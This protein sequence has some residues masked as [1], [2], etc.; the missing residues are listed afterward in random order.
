MT[1]G[2]PAVATCI[3][4]SQT[5]YVGQVL[6]VRYAGRHDAIIDEDTLSSAPT[7]GQRPRPLLCDQW[8]STEHLDR[9]RL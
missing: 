8:Q 9:P 4:S 7:K 5:I 3:N 6:R 2:Q 1:G